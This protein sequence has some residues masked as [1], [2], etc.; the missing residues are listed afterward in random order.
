MLRTPPRRPSHPAR[1]HGLRDIVRALG[2]TTVLVTHDQEE[3][4]DVADRVVI[5]NKGAI[6]QQ[7]TPEV[8]VW[9]WVWGRCVVRVGVLCGV[10]A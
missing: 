2:V 4:W 6:E 10:G 9:V 1:R 3:A 5:F 7:G 8:W